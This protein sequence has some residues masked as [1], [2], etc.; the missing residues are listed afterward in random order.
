MSM[1]DGRPLSTVAAL[2]GIKDM[3]QVAG[4]DFM[5]E[6]LDK[7]RAMRHFFYGSTEE[8]LLQLTEKLKARFHGLNVVGIF[9]PPFRSLQSHEI[10]HITSMINLAKPDIVWIGLGAPKQEYWMAEHWEELKPAILMGVGA[11]FDFNAGKISRAPGW[12][13]KNNIEWFYRLSQEPGRLWKR[14]LVTNSL[15]FYYLIKYFVAD[16][17]MLHRKK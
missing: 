3:S 15:F 4:P 7:H 14:Y 1:P 17:F 2:S 12:M 13:R 5:L 9:S 8:I 10:N 16:K 6:M 11:A